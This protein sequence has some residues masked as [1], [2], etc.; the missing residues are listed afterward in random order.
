MYTRNL[1]MQKPY[2][3]LHWGRRA[4]RGGCR[5]WL[6]RGDR[7]YRVDWVSWVD[8]MAGDPLKTQEFL[9]CYSPAKILHVIIL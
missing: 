7:E 3:M 8:V 9:E 5:T 1:Y 2:R 6:E 4:A